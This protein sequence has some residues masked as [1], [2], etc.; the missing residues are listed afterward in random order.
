MLR[1]FEM[2]KKR[3]RRTHTAEYKAEVV[4]MVR[5]GGKT[6]SE[7]CRELGVA[8]S[9]VYAWVKQADIDDVESPV[10]ALTTSERQELAQLRREV[11]ELKKEREFLG[12]AAAFFASQKK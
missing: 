8:E 3:T 5:A 9:S 7:L 6:V 1:V 11:H 10:G 12:K 2:T 4:R